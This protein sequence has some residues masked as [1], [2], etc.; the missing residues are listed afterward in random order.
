MKKLS[1]IIAL[2]AVVLGS[3]AAYACLVWLP[4]QVRSQLDAQLMT[5]DADFDVS[6]PELAVNPFNGSATLADVTFQHR[7]LPI[8]GTIGSIEIT[9]LEEA[10]TALTIANPVFRDG[11]QTSIHA[12]LIEIASVDQAYVDEL[13]ETW[14]YGD[15]ATLEQMMSEATGGAL[16]GVVAN[17]LRMDFGNVIFELGRLTIGSMDSTRINGLS[18]EGASWK[19]PDSASVQTGID[20]GSINVQS[21]D[22]YHLQ[23]LYRALID[24]RDRLARQLFINTPDRFLEQL[25]IRDILLTP[26][27]QLPDDGSFWIGSIALEAISSK[28]ISTFGINRIRFDGKADDETILGGIGAITVDSIPFWPLT[29]SLKRADQCSGAGCEDPKQVFERLVGI[30]AEEGGLELGGISVNGIEMHMRS[31]GAKE[32]LYTLHS[33]GFSI[34]TFTFSISENGRPYLE[35]FTLRSEA[36]ESYSMAFFDPSSHPLS[37]F[38]DMDPDMIEFLRLAGEVIRANAVPLT[39]LESFSEISLSTDPK[40]GKAAFL[41]QLKAEQRGDLRF[42]ASIGDIP[43]NVLTFKDL[44]QAANA[45]LAQG[46]S[47]LGASL[48]YTDQGLFDLFV[49]LIARQSRQSREQL[50]STAL[51]GIRFNVETALPQ[52]SSVILPPVQ[53]FADDSRSL[54]VSLRPEQPVVFSA[55]PFLLQSAPEQLLEIIGFE[56]IA[57]E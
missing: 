19:D 32:S 24:G 38:R 8:S 45:M 17:D 54:K 40:T 26:P 10:K 56:I 47:L 33:G 48:T 12:G 2:I 25:E 31:P 18:L 21:L 3:S 16:N 1:A 22:H 23:Q 49:D 6:Y 35:N 42:D 51:Q 30:V 57:N 5:I 4:Q 29:E 37:T 9:P 39:Y 34:P 44:D 28:E 36:E 46:S 41:M 53:Q 27:V 11:D 20:V 15:R 52:L 55:L 50:I 43:E 14:A 7:Q 13:L